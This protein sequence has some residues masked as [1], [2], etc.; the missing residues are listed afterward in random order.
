MPLDV[1]LCS[2]C[3]PFVHSLALSAIRHEEYLMREE[4]TRKYRV[5][6]DLVGKD[7]FHNR[8]WMFSW[9]PEVLYV[10][11]VSSSGANGTCTGT[12][13][14][15]HNGGSGGGSGGSGGGSGGPTMEDAKCWDFYTKDQ[16]IELHASLDYRGKRENDLKDRLH[17][18]YFDLIEAM[19]TSQWTFDSFA[20]DEVRNNAKEQR[21]GATQKNNV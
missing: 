8:Y 21:K 15:G 20:L 2:F 3:A 1:S 7:R 11:Y 6:A 18:M 4:K 16:I 9:N 10:E 5:G 19:R 14:S 12:A 13:S 17:N